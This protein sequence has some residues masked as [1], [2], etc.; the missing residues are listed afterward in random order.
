MLDV[1]YLKILL[2][3]VCFS[4]VAGAVMTIGGPAVNL[5]ER[6]LEYPRRT[7]IAACFFTLGAGVA[8]GQYGFRRSLFVELLGALS[9]LLG[10]GLSISFLLSQELVT[11]RQVRLTAA[12]LVVYLITNALYGYSNHKTKFSNWEVTTLILLITAAGL[13]A[14]SR[15]VLVVEPLAFTLFVLAVLTHT[16]FIVGVTKQPDVGVIEGGTRL[17]IGYVGLPFE[18]PFYFIGILRRLG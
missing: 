18:V 17:F 12:A 4:I 5:P 10:L 9:V 7:V 1:R 13:V 2:V 6:L 3:A 16:L 14:L 8:L 15:V 11:L